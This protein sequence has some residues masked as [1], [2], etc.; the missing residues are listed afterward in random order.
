[1]LQDYPF[2]LSIAGFDPSAGAGILADIKTF[3]QLQTYGLAALSC[4][5]LQTETSFSSLEWLPTSSLESTVATLCQQYPLKAIKIGAIRDSTQLM[6][7]V[8]TAR[9]YRPELFICWDPIL[10]SSTGID[11][12]KGALPSIAELSLIDLITPNYLEIA[13][14]RLP[15]EAV[16]ECCKRISSSCAVFLKGGHHPNNLGLDQLFTADHVRE[17]L[18]EAFNKATEKHGSGCVLSSAISAFIAK[19]YPL[20]EACKVAKDYTAKFLSSNPSLL[21]NHHV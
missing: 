19:D 5:T 13:A 4:H 14:F 3:E 10:R 2:V 1:M 12:F 15:Q 11:F 9:S 18:P 20:A 17:Y 7:I 16:A 8:T 6:R 21:G